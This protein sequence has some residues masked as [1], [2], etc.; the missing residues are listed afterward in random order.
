MN[1]E[2]KKSY[3]ISNLLE[4]VQVNSEKLKYFK[5]YNFFEDSEKKDQDRQIYIYIY[6]RMERVIRTSPKMKPKNEETERN[7]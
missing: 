1:L 4:D 3:D 6:M 2:R 7:M 5:W